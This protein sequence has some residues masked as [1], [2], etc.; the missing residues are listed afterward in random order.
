MAKYLLLW[1]LNLD[2]MPDDPKVRGEGWAMMLGMIKQDLEAGIDTDWG[3][4]VGETRGYTVSE[5]DPVE[6]MKLL[7]R[8]APYVVF[9]VH[10]VVSVDDVIEV[11][12]SLSG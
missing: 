10:Q 4:F 12:K 2:K 6:L 11:A 1:E 7:Q 3:C 8:F 5:N 9:E